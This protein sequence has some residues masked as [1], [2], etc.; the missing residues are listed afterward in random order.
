MNLLGPKSAI[1]KQK[2]AE[3]K[4]EQLELDM[5]RGLDLSGTFGTEKTSTGALGIY[6]KLFS[7]LLGGHFRARIVNQLRKSLIPW[8]TST[9]HSS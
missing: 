8:I 5:E 4:F 9:S 7:S 1:Q 3:S 6:G 2:E